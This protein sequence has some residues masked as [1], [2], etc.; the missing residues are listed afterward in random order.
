MYFFATRVSQV[1]AKTMKKDFEERSEFYVTQY[2]LN[3]VLS[4]DFNVCCFEF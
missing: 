2:L 1:I 3:H 4:S